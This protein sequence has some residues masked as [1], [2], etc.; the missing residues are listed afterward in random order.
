MRPDPQRVMY[1]IVAALMR[2]ILPE[3]RTPFAQQT[4]GLTGMVLSLMAQEY[5]RSA[6]RL[7]EENAA[8]IELL[9]RARSSLPDTALHQRI[10][11]AVDTVPGADLRVSALQA[12]NDALR[13]LLID[14]QAAVEQVESDEARALDGLIWE[15][16][17]ESTR[18]RHLERGV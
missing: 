10:D 18:R 2:D 14:V 8:V 12:E 6:A 17:K 3:V 1:G 9:S 13:A 16:L 7:V 15:E 11:A 4:V 5:D